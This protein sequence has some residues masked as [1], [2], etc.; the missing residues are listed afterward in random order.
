MATAQTLIDVEAGTLTLRVQDQSVV[1]SLFKATKRPG[2][3]QNCMC[4]DV[5]DN[6]LHAEIMPRLTSDPLL[7][8]LHGFENKNTEDEEVF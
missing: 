1:F 7:N 2:D 6:L 3:V 5:L 4:V 8:V